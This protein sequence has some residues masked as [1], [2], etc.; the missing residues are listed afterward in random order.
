M[1]EGLEEIRADHEVLGVGALAVEIDELVGEML[2]IMLEV[3]E[4]TLG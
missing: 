3:L 2:R 1:G 4:V